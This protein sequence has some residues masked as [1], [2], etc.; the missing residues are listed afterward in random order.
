MAVPVQPPN[1]TGISSATATSR[2]AD[3]IQV[4]GLNFSPG[5]KDINDVLIYVAIALGA[6]GVASMMRGRK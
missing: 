5:K 4:G 6:I 1:L 2:G 3:S